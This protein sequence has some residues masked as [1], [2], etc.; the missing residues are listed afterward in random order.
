MTISKRVKLSS[1][2]SLILGLMF[3]GM[4]LSSP[5]VTN[6]QDACGC[7]CS[8]PAGAVKQGTGST[9]ANVD[10]ACGAN[11]AAVGG[12]PL[13]CVKAGEKP[14]NFGLCWT[15]QECENSQ[16]LLPDGETANSTWATKRTS[17][18]PTAQFSDSGTEERYCYNP[19]IPVKLSVAIT[20]LTSKENKFRKSPENSSAQVSYGIGE[21]IDALYRLLIPSAA[22]IAVVLLMISGLQYMLAGGRQEAI[23]KAKD[24]MQKTVIGLVLILTAYSVAHLVDPQLTSFE[25]LK[26]PRVRPVLFLDPSS[27][28][29][30]LSEYF[31]I[32]PIESGA[33]Q[34]GDQGRIG[35]KLP[36]VSEDVAGDFEE[37]SMCNYSACEKGRAYRCVRGGGSSDDLFCA[38]CADSYIQSGGLGDPNPEAPPPTP[39]V[40]GQFETPPPGE[41]VKSGE[42]FLCKYETAGANECVEVVFPAN[43]SATSFDCQAL[44]EEAEKFGA[45]SCRAYDLA[46]ILRTANVFSGYQVDSIDAFYGSSGTFDIPSQGLLDSI[47]TNDPCGFAPPDSN[48]LIT[49]SSFFLQSAVSRIDCV[50]A[51][52]I[53][54]LTGGVVDTLAGQASNAINS[55]TSLF[56]SE[57]N[58]ELDFTGDTCTDVNGNQGDCHEDW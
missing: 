42:Q 41:P 23:S 38:R 21:Y 1:I 44:R 3:A 16:V 17:L 7:W 19:P 32:T 8:T 31:E 33:E 39:Q 15:Q 36:T 46:G 10:D 54:T 34:C 51:G 50:A 28:C 4:F 29:E 35:K 13:S 49:N 57:S 9:A 30:K 40:C 14:T 22:I 58:V 12:K 45:A 18:C 52:D 20:T 55:L 25:R 43:T 56:G 37:R 2:L 6:A 26:V 11:C 27:S 53:T 47:C 48:C 24:R 5:V